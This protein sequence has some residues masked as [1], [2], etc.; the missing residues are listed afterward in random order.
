MSAA[1]GV[2]L[3]VEQ[4][5]PRLSLTQADSERREVTGTMILIDVFQE[6]VAFS[7]WSPSNE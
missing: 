1:Q 7:P 6:K 3:G 2:E 4:G 5:P